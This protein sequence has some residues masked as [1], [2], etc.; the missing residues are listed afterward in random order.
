M[1]L[2][3]HVSFVDRRGQNTH[4]DS[5]LSGADSID[6]VIMVIAANNNCPHPQD[7]KY[8][9]IIKAADIEN[10]VIAQNKIDLVKEEI[11]AMENFAQIKAFIQGTKVEKSPIV[12][13]SA[14]LKY[15]IDALCHYICKLPIPKRD[16][17]SD[18]EFSVTRLVILY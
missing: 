8:L 2:I 4:L 11:K 17:T 5:L 13:I 18:P 9:E 12:P 6:A 14:Q 1:K 16:L 10:M 7:L 15:N 3:R